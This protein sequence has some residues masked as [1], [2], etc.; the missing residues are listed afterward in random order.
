MQASQIP[1]LQELQQHNQ[2]VVWKK[3]ERDGKLTKVP[4]Q[5]KNPQFGAKSNDPTTWA[6][7]QQA[8]RV[9]NDGKFTGIGY[10]FLRDQKITGIDLDHCIAPDG[11][12]SNFAQ[13]AITQF[14]SYTELSPSETGLHIF[15]RGVLP[16]TLAPTVIDPAF[17][18]QK[19]E[20]YDHTH[21]FTVSGKHYAGTPCTINDA[22]IALLDLHNR[23]K[24][25]HKTETSTRPAVT[26][27]TDLSDSDLLEKMFS[28]ACGSDIRALWYGNIGEKNKSDADYQLCYHLAFW[29]SKDQNRIKRMFNQSALAQRDKW[30]ERDDYQERTTRAAIDACKRVYDPTQLA[31]YTPD[32]PAPSNGNGKH[33]NTAPPEEKKETTL[34]RLMRIAN[35]ARPI[36]TPS[37]ALYARVPVNGHYEIVSMSEKG[38]GFRRWLVHRYKKEYGT[39]PNSDALSQTMSGVLADAEFEGQKAEVYTRIASHNGCIYLDI[40]DD[41]WQC[42]EISA[43]GWRIIKESPVYFRR[44]NGMLPLPVPTSGGDLD[45]LREFTNTKEDKDFKLIIAWLL[46]I[47]H[48]TGPYAV[49]NLNGESGSAKSKVTTYLRNFID[50]NEAPARNTPKDDR[51]VAITAQNNMVFALDNLSSLPLWLSDILCRIATGSGYATRALYSDDAECVFHAKRPIIM[52]GISDGLITQGDLLSRTISVTLQPPNGYRSEKEMDQLFKEKHPSMLGAW[53]DAVS[54]ALRGHTSVQLDRTP[55]LIDFAQWVTAAESALGWK[56]GSFLSVFMDNQENA[57]SIVV[58]SSPVAKAI[59][60]FMKSNPKGFDGYVSGLHEELK[61]YEIYRDTK[62]A[63][64]TANR[65]SGDLKRVAPSLRIQGINIQMLGHTRNGTRVILVTIGDDTPPPCDDQM[66]P[67]DD[68][69]SPIVTRMTPD[70]MPFRTQ[71]HKKCDDGD[72]QTPLFSSFYPPEEEEKIKERER[73]RE[74]SNLSSQ[75]SQSSID[76]L[77]SMQAEIV[78]LREQVQKVKT[79]TGKIFRKSE[80]Q[81]GYWNANLLPSEYDSWVEECVVSGDPLKLQVAIV[82]MRSTLAA[83]VGER[84][85]VM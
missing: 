53:L 14:Q 69:F 34:I 32:T 72:D 17:P 82:A 2:W 79:P 51:E 78:E 11:T 84:Y 16:S 49:L 22:Q 9:C 43:D 21:F 28:S 23:F 19:I 25:Q 39:A 50:P 18:D 36:R 38:S 33:T 80:G 81:G 37:H 85:E 56:K 35:D 20:M 6:S 45:D 59:V 62:N 3:E 61:K 27:P 8:M 77:N 41:T 67:C 52:N 64:K 70:S 58:E 5:P 71:N 73:T 63:P 10:E 60:Q 83:Q 65:L 46:G 42:V 24:K 7:Y 29:T 75:S 47:G 12:L 30:E 4:Y 48:P 54:T 57:S 55:R 44:P 1:A 68:E 26:A 66:P 13:E 76:E 74:S 31:V 40:G 15:V